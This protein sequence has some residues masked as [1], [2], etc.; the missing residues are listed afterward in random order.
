MIDTHSHIYAEEFDTDR[1]EA[2]ERAWSA[3][4]EALILPDIDS[5][6]R[7]RMVALAQQHADRCYAMAGLHPTS[8]NDNPRWQQELDMVEKMLQQS[9]VK[10]CGVGEIGLD[11]YWSEEFYHQQRE[12]L[13]AQLELALQYNLPVVFH[14]RSAYKQMLDAIATYRGRGL[15]GVFHAWADSAETARKLERMGEF[16][17]GI[18][19]VVTFKNS[20]L[21]KVVAELPTELLLLETDSPY[22]TPVPHRGKRNES[23]YVE[24]VCRKIAD[25]HGLSF[26][27]VD[28]IT[29][30]SAKQLFGIS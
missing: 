20:G 8:V 7:N 5:E 14:T 9:P 4:V 22:L 13:H 30:A 21:D 24:Y 2:L 12:V 16:K 17:F 6:S 10:L 1:E 15:R 26:E 25:I 11:L 28:S 18:G 3:G 29:T 23:A 27:Q 19:G